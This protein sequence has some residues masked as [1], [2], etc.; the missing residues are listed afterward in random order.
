MT[1]NS[2][3]KLHTEADKPKMDFEACE[4]SIASGGNPHTKLPKT[5]IDVEV[6]A[7]PGGPDGV[8]FTLDIKKHAKGQA[9]DL[10]K[11]GGPYRIVFDLDAKGGLDIRFDAG[12]PFF[13]AVDN[14]SC[15]PTGTPSDQ[16]M[17]D[18]CDDDT[19]IVIDWNYGTKQDLRYQMSFVDSEGKRMPDCDPIILNGGGIKTLI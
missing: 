2:D 15:P 10:P 19:L 4:P 11:D 18:K 1:N 14:G 3:E 17:V 9:I 7:R 8:T 12:S 13:C 16:I 6:I 5:D